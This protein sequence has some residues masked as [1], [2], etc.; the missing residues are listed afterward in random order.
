M[1]IAPNPAN[2]VLVISD[3]GKG[4]REIEIVDLFGRRVLKSE[5]R[6]QRSEVS[7]N[8]ASLSPGIYFLKVG[9]EV[10][11]FVKE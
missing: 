9:N 3:K 11:K 10:R 4:I 1:T 2:D 5:V 8:V 7:I 6:G